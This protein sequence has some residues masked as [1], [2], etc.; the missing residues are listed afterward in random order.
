M[1]CLCDM[2]FMNFLCVKIAGHIMP[3]AKEVLY[4]S[5]SY[6]AYLGGAIA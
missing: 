6:F 3:V 2:A 5:C 4:V 1:M